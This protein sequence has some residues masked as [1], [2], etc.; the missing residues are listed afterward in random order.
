MAS[1][2]FFVKKKNGSLCLVQDY[3]ALNAMTVKNKYPLLLIPELIRQ[4]CG[5][6]YFTKLDIRWGYNNIRVHPGDEWKIAFCTNRGLFKPLIM[7]FGLTNSPA[8][9]QMMMNDIFCNLIMEGVVVVYMDDILIFTRTRAEHR[10]V[11][12]HVMEVLKKHKLFL[13]PEKCSFEQA[14]VE[15][16]GLII[17][18]DSMEMDPVKIKGV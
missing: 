8:T 15:Y 16:L 12:H 9:F 13:H 5:A 3:H 11:V 14:W 18:E 2:V 4:L 10:E 17:S 1:P 6:R 7:F